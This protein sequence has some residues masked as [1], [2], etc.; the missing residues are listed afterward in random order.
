MLLRLTQAAR[1]LALV[2]SDFL[3]LVLPLLAAL[4]FAAHSGVIVTFRPVIAALI[5]FRVS[6]EIGTCRR[7]SHASRYGMIYIQS[8]N[9]LINTPE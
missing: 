1:I 6:S 8:R 5:F 7:F 9:H 3:G 2:S 4:I